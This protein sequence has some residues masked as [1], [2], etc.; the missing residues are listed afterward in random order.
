MG[1]WWKVMENDGKMMISFCIDQFQNGPMEANWKKKWITKRQID[2]LDR[3]YRTCPTLGPPQPQPQPDPHPHPPTTS[4]HYWA[5]RLPALALPPPS[6]LKL[7]CVPATV[8][9]PGPDHPGKWMFFFLLKCH[10]YLL[11]ICVYIYICIIYMYNI[12]ICIIYIYIQC[13]CICIY[14]YTAKTPQSSY[15][16]IA[17][18]RSSTL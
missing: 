18:L 1:K 15:P 3:T 12:Y 4:N 9:D 2:G 14:I 10:T 11:Y 8:A 17:S 6:A 5:H 13:I 7:E 16:G